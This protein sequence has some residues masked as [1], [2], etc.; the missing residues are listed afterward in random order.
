MAAPLRATGAFAS[1]T[2]VNMPLSEEL[3]E[4]CS[5]TE[6]NVANACD[7]VPKRSADASV[8][9][10]LQSACSASSISPSTAAE[11][12]DDAA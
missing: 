7:P 6:G 4:S 8:S 5:W 1:N 9:R 11:A 3:L 10:A 12:E 2:R